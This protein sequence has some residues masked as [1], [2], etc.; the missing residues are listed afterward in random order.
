MLFL[1][2]FPFSCENIFI[3]SSC[4]R[5]LEPTQRARTRLD[6]ILENLNSPRATDQPLGRRREEPPQ[7]Q[8]KPQQEKTPGVK[9]DAAFCSAA[10]QSFE[11]LKCFFFFFIVCGFQRAS[12]RTN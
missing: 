5:R 7:S 9:A 4:L 6:E 1:N 8:E 3:L 10:V 12:R 2:N 11:S